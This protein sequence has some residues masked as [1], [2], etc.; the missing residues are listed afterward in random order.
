M[1]SE[2]VLLLEACPCAAISTVFAVQFHY[3]EEKVAGAVILS[4]VLSILTLPITAFIITTL[5]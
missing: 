1:A 4:T 5:L 3:D 2:V